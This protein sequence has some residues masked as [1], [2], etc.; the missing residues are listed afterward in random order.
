MRYL[1]KS[2]FRTTSIAVKM[3]GMFSFCFLAVA[4]LAFTRTTKQRQSFKQENFLIF[5]GT[6]I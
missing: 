4:I 6:I 1:L 5:L 3:L 2:I